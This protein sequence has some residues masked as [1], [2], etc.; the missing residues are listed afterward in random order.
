[1]LLYIVWCYTDLNFIYIIW[2]EVQPYFSWPFYTPGKYFVQSS[3][4][5]R[6]NLCKKFS[7]MYYAK[8]K[9]RNIQQALYLQ[10]CNIFKTFTKIKNV[11]KKKDTCINLTTHIPKKS[12]PISYSLSCYLGFLIRILAYNDCSMLCKDI[13]WHL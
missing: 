7:L 4:K 12:W 13:L 11:G 2:R 3:E 6:V 8:E 5:L 10:Y 1:M 9:L